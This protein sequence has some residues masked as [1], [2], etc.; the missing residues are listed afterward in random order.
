M[1]DLPDT[2]RR[3]SISARALSAFAMRLISA[4]RGRKRNAGEQ[5]K[6]LI[7]RRRLYFL[8]PDVDAARRTRDDL[9]LATV[10]DRHLHFLARRGTDLDGLREANAIQKTDLVHGGQ[11]GMAVGGLGGILL[12]IF[13]L[14]APPLGGSPLQYAVVLA[15]ALGGAAFGAWVGSLVGAGV[16]NSRLKAFEPAMQSGQVLLMVDVPFHRVSE[17]RELVQRRHP[18]ATSAVVE[19]TLPA[20]P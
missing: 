16:P 1:V 17:I 3:H 15:T 5:S 8:L 12:G 2:F 7:M 13:L 9:L 11:I 4:E 14:L 6:E 20:F 10:E 18:E 19:P